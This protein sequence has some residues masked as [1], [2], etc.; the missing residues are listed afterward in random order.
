[1]TP[2]ELNRYKGKF[3]QG[4]TESKNKKQS[5]SISKLVISITSFNHNGKMPKRN[6]AI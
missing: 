3:I 1:M 2:P 6:G 5:E 4:N